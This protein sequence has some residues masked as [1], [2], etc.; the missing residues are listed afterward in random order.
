MTMRAQ[1]ATET[2]N[3]SAK[4][5]AMTE[6]EIC[7][8]IRDSVLEQRLA[9]GTKL[10]EESL[11]S[12]FGAGRTTVRRAFL[13]LSR[14]NIIELQKNKG[15]VVA[16]PSPRE[17]REVFEARRALEAALVEKAV[18]KC[19]AADIENLRQHLALEEEA[20]RRADIAHWIR[21]TGEFHLH[22]ARIARNEPMYHFLEQLVF[23]T[24]L[25]IT[26]YGRHGR[27]APSCKGDDH[28]QIVCALEARDSVAATNVL[29][30]H[31]E[32]IESGLSFSPRDSG[33]DLHQIFHGAQA[34]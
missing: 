7:R 2:E 11:C 1:Q 29:L 8:R 21:L 30:H 22:V 4:R 10:T 6:D 32:A 3:L 12:V 31:L 23:R 17:A 18:E 27:S 14:D 13:L 34:S 33:Q 15:A 20:L 9:P 19:T 26:L 5:S 24:S 16:S 28:S 25:I